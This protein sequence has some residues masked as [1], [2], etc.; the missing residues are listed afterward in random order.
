MIYNKNDQTQNYAGKFRHDLRYEM[1]RW[2][3]KTKNIW[4]SIILLC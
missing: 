4:N 2:P 3:E 1:T